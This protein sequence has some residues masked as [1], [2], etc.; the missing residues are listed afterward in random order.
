M[1]TRVN[2]HDRHLDDLALRMAEVLDGEELFDVACAAALV[3]AYALARGS[4][5]ANERKATVEK[6]VTFIRE[7]A[8]RTARE[9]DG[10]RRGHAQ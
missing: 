10:I 4:S 3:T 2:G 9:D 1:N 8:E 6:V 7:Q 5:D